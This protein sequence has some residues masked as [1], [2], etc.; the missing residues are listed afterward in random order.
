MSASLV[1]NIELRALAVPLQTKDDKDRDTNSN[2]DITLN[3]LSGRL[4]CVV[5]ILAGPR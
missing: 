5:Q 2:L 3:S 1:G 4:H